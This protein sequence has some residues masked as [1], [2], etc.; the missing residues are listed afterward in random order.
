[1]NMYKQREKLEKIARF[2]NHY[3]W[4]YKICQDKINFNEEVRANY[5]SDILAYFQDTLELIDKKLEKS[6]YQESVFYSIGLLQ[7]IYV[8]QD[9][10]KELLYIFKL[11]KDNVSNED[12]RNINR[13]IRNELIGHPIRRAKDKKEELVSSVIFGKE[14]ANNSIHYVLYAKSNNFKGQEIFHN[15]SDIVERHQEFLLKNLEKI[16]IKIDIILKYFLKRIQKIYFFIENSI[17]FNGLI[18]LVNQQFE[19]IFRENYL[20]NNDCLIE[21]YNKRHSHN[22]YEFVLNLFVDELKKMI[23]YTTDDIRDITGDNIANFEI[24]FSINLIES[25]FDFDYELGKLQDR[26]PVFNP[27][28]FKKLFPDDM[29]ICAELENMEVNIHSNLEYYCSY[30]YLIYLIR[31]KT[32]YQTQ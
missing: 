3:I 7:T 19:Y 17:P 22:R 1:M 12:N 9:L 24:K 25:N 15:V 11:N 16:E 23:K 6:S 20:F 4:R 8:Q 26:H 2:W 30:E 5:F 32:K 29:E 21:I 14:L 18:R 13:R 28:Y 27:Q 10:V 31:S